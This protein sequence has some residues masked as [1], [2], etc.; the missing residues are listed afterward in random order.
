[1]FDIGTG[2]GITIKEI[3]SKLKIKKENIIYKKK[4]INEIF[5]SVAD[6]KNLIKK[7]KNFKFKK[8]EDYLDIKETL[9]SKKYQIKIIKK[10][11]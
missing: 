3:V 7:I 8:I 1:M 5:D 9:A 11:K 4:E 10:I 6:N 2:K